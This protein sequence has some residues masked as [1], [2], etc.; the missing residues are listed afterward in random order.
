MTSRSALALLSAVALA[1]SLHAQQPQNPVFRSGVNL[2][3][4]DVTAV[5]KDGKPVR[6]LAAADFVVTLEG[7]TRPVQT[8]DFIEFG[9]GTS[10]AAATPSVNAGM[11]TPTTAAIPKPRYEPRAV[12]LLFDDLSLKAGDGKGMAVAAQRTLAQFGPDDLIGVAVTSALVPPVNPTADR[13]ALNAAVK[14]LVGR[15]DDVTY[16]YFVSAREANDIDRDFP[17]ETLPSVTRRECAATGDTSP[18]CGDRV[19]QSA[20]ALASELKRRAGMQL[21]AYQRAIAAVKKFGGAKVIIAMSEGVAT[22]MEIELLQKRLD[23]V[24]TN[25]AESGVRFYAMS[26][27][28]GYSDVTVVGLPQAKAHAGDQ[29]R[30]GARIEN[31]RV[32]YDGIA[33]VAMAAGGEAFHVIGQADRFFT[34]IEAETSAIYRLAV[35]APVGAD[36]NRFLDAKVTVNRP[37]VTVRAN[38]KALSAKPAADPATVDQQLRAAIGAGG[39]DATVPVNVTA[40]VLSESPRR[41]GVTVQLPSDVAGPVTLMFSLVD[42]TGKPVTGGAGRKE[43]PQPASGQGYRFQFALPLATSGHLTLRVAAADAN[44]HVGKTETVVVVDPEPKPI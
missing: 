17:R 34:R 41:L 30:N 13:A 21:E 11:S 37:G 40:I 42:D 8:V 10:R 32:L 44:G 2:V 39:T 6:G 36:K 5:D 23:V 22:N 20:K 19:R 1:A 33:S 14:K 18:G 28:P 4:L 25:A 26:E 7:Q 43:L 16:P 35:D 38:R 3:T 15:A 31:A 29:D 24:M 9:S 12:V 27:E